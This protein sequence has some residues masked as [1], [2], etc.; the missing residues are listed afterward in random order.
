MHATIDLRQRAIP[1][2]YLRHGLCRAW[3]LCST[4]ALCAVGCSREAPHVMPGAVAGASDVIGSTWDLCTLLGPSTG[5]QGI[6]GTD[7]GITVSRPTGSENPQ[8]SILFGDTWAKATDVCTYPIRHADDLQ[9]SLPVQRPAALAPGP[10]SAASS[11][12]ACSG[13]AVTLADASD[14]TSWRRIRLFKDSSARM[15][16]NQVDTGMLRTPVAAF[17]DRVHTFG[18]FIRDEPTTC[19]SSNDCPTQ[20]LCSSDAAYSG[21]TLGSCQPHPTLTRDAAPAFCMTNDDCPSGSLCI[22]LEQ[23]YCLAKAP[24][25]VQRDGQQASPPWYDEDPRRGM[26]LNVYLGS[27]LWPDRPEDYA[28]GFK[29]ATNKFPNASAR[30]IKHFDPNDP[31]KNDYSPGTETLLMWGR[32][33]FSTTRGWQ[34]LMFLLY[35]PLAGLLDAE[36]FIHWAPKYF[37]GYD[38]AGKPKWSD[39]EADAQPVYGVDENLELQHGRLVWNWRQPEFDYVNQ[40]SLMFVAP[41]SRWVMLYGGDGPAFTVSDAASGDK[42]APVHA[43]AVPGAIYL[44]SAAHPWGRA[45][46]AA[47]SAEAWSAARPVLTRIAAAPYLAC[48]EDSAPSSD[49]TPADHRK[50]PADVLGALGGLTTQLP[51]DDWLKASATCIA[52]NAALDL[53]YSVGDDSSGH[54]YGANLIEEWTDDVSARV[55]GLADGERA[56]E[57]YW[58]VSTWNPYQVVVMK[59]QLRSR[60]GQLQ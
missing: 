48:D 28:T 40:M 45:T 53:Q 11:S 42:L 16:A 39:V 29:F 51:F 50:Q 24:F 44:R 54:L 13:L 18:V 34:A 49:C 30:T 41:L 27:A 7:L 19:R 21:K 55:P 8:L 1:L 59:T 6:Y 38:A 46:R 47:N 37:A 23:G 2:D 20:M 60:S 57:L 58:N 25:T 31:S 56:V 12:S 5:R 17:S 35:Q 3:L 9:A 43:Q 14:P 4:I 32:P 26:A 22:D 10:P 52:G 36:G 33:T 15:S